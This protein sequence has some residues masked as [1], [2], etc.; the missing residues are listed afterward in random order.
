MGGIVSISQ[1]HEFCEQWAPT[2][3]LKSFISTSVKEMTGVSENTEH[4]K[5][6]KPE[7]RKKDEEE[8]LSLITTITEKIL[9]SWEFDPE[10]TEKDSQLN[11]ARGPVPPSDVLLNHCYQQKT[12]VKKHQMNFWI[13]N[14]HLG[15]KTSGLHFQR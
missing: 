8:V 5:D 2:K 14:L 15:M 1:D 3:H 9:N 4:C 7:R 12:K 11:I 6:V 10:N 13:N